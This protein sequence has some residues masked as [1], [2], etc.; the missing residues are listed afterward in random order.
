[1]TVGRC[2]LGWVEWRGMGVRVGRRVLT[3]N[4]FRFRL[5]KVKLVVRM[6]SAGKGS[7]V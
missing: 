4:W 6:V 5:G 2:W 3:L 1:M 7:L